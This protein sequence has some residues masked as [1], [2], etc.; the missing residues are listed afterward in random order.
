MSWW[1][2]S[3]FQITYYHSFF[4]CLYPSLDFYFLCATV[5][6]F[7]SSDVL[8]A[9]HENAA[10]LTQGQVP[11]RE[12]FL[13]IIT[14]RPWKWVMQQSRCKK[15]LGELSHRWEIRSDD[16]GQGCSFNTMLGAYAHHHRI[17]MTL[18]KDNLDWHRRRIAFFRRLP[19]GDMRRIG[20]DRSFPQIRCCGWQK[21]LFKQRT[22]S[23]Y[24]NRVKA[25][26]SSH[27]GPHN[28]NPVTEAHHKHNAAQRFKKLYQSA[29][30]NAREHAKSFAD[31][32]EL[33]QWSFTFVY[34]ADEPLASC[35]Q[36]DRC[37]RT[38]GKNS[39][40]VSFAPNR[41]APRRSRIILRVR[42]SWR[43]ISRGLTVAAIW[44][45]TD[46][47]EVAHLVVWMRQISGWQRGMQRTWDQ[48]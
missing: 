5:L 31:H 45:D 18:L 1:H 17:V 44:H 21:M 22:I 48:R 7:L 6:L 4:V 16:F 47:G 14:D 9:P 28:D 40:C 19:A 36:T 26:F 42:R 34:A 24:I 23:K 38:E 10:N 32:W 27:G 12:E 15:A 30:N 11:S 13:G 20:P 43:L 25:A 2:Q 8:A 35:S 37:L 41:T 29:T 33:P 46:F 3:V 39:F